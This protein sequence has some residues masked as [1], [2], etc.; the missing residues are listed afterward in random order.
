M[1]E[2][3]GVECAI[4]GVTG[5]AIAPTWIALENSPIQV[6]HCRHEGGAAFCRSGSAF[7]QRSPRRRVATTGPGITNAITGLCAARWENAKVIFLSAI[8]PAAKRG[9][10]ACQETSSYRMPIS[11]LFTSG[12]L[13]HYAV[14]IESAEE[15]PEVRRRLASGLAQPGGFVAHISISPT[16]QSSSSQTSFVPCL[17]FAI[18]TN[19]NQGRNYPMC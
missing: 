9:R 16:L 8:T 14:A 10:W 13:F 19:N 7:C 18:A 12:S 2:K 15:L 1:L 17:F 3:L 4:C 5:G 11:E 6:F